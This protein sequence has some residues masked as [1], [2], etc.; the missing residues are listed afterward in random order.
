MG[1]QSPSLN[2]RD[3]DLICS[4]VSIF[5]AFLSDC[6]IQLK[7]RMTDLNILI[8]LEFCMTFYKGLQ[9]P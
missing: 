3:S 1:F 8:N 5:T 6:T 2:S 7:L 4:F 9:I